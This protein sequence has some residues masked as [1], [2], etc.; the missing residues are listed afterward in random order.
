MQANRRFNFSQKQNEPQNHKRHIAYFKATATAT[1][2]KLH[3][4]GGG[5]RTARRIWIERAPWA[6]RATSADCACEGVAQGRAWTRG[7]WPQLAIP[8]QGGS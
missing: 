4:Q 5:V 7:R 3:S 8:A 2:A 1:K 6:F